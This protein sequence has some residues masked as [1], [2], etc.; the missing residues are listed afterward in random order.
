MND[1]DLF[2]PGDRFQEVVTA[3]R[4]FI[5][6]PAK[7]HREGEWDL[8]YV[9]FIYRSMKI[10]VGNAVEAR[11]FNSR[12]KQWADLSVDFSSSK[13]V[14]LW[15]MQIPVMARTHLVQYKHVLNRSVDRQDIEA[16]TSKTDTP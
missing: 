13:L 11:I 1:I 5:S 9:Q 6:K 14:D 15:G 7:R 12:S 16:I 8:E 3:G 10:E 4:E 2:V